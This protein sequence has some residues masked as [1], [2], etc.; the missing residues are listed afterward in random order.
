[1]I[2][3]SIEADLL[4]MIRVSPVH[5]RSDDPDFLRHVYREGLGRAPEFDPAGP[6]APDLGGDVYFKRAH[7]ICSV[8][9]SEEDSR[10]SYDE[11]L[12][13]FAAM[14]G[15]DRY[16]QGFVETFQTLYPSRADFNAAIDELIARICE[17]SRRQD[18]IVAMCAAA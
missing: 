5:L 13:A 18:R 15:Y 6:D 14:L 9:T 10:R 12:N 4:R 8:A 11:T 1:M 17:N 7:L 3:F 16:R 2:P